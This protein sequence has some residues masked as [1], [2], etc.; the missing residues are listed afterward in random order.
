MLRRTSRA[1]SFSPSALLLLIVITTKGGGRAAMTRRERT[2]QI[3]CFLQRATLLIHLGLD[4][5]VVLHETDTVL[6]GEE[7][8]L[9][10]VCFR[11]KEKWRIALRWWRSRAIRTMTSGHQW[12]KWSLRSRYFQPRISSSFCSVFCHWIRRFIIELFLRFSLRF[13]KLCSLTGDLEENPLCFLC[14]LCFLCNLCF[15]KEEIVRILTSS[16]LSLY[17]NFCFCFSFLETVN[18][19]V[20][21]LNGLKVAFRFLF[22]STAFLG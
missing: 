2:R 9:K 20:L 8:A 18:L 21:E 10:W 7:R 15:S 19:F 1:A 17:L 13:G 12:W 16:Y 5:D 11:Y 4:Y 6:A 22:V 3:L 14:S